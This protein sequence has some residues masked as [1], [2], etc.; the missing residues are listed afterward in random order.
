[1]VALEQTR[2][3]KICK[4]GT[5]VRAGDDDVAL[6]QASVDDALPL[7]LDEAA[8][9]IDED[10]QSV[11]GRQERVTGIQLP[12]K[13][14]K[15]SPEILVKRFTRRPL[16]QRVQHPV[17][18]AMLEEC[19]YAPTA[20]QTL[21]HGEVAKAVYGGRARGNEGDLHPWRCRHERAPGVALS[22]SV[23]G[24]GLR[25]QPPLPLRRQ[26]ELQGR[27]HG[28]GPSR[29][30]IGDLLRRLWRLRQHVRREEH[31]RPEHRGEQRR[32]CWEQNVRIEE[33]VRRDQRLGR[34]A[35]CCAKCPTHAR[36]ARLAEQRCQGGVQRESPAGP[37]GVQQRRGQLRRQVHAHGA[38]QD[39]RSEEDDV[40]A[41]RHGARSR[42]A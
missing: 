27:L 11:L 18:H 32:I 10:R 5:L 40:A 4:Q 28:V 30:H 13:C 38:R 31:I 21:L 20:A 19:G 26:L 36:H 35:G 6:R 23:H 7:Q 2:R 25:N 15:V 42:G 17:V 16:S 8:Q 1:M 9:H 37:A 14:R 39:G 3:S 41:G 33:L 29:Q 12:I 24:D 22:G 34:E